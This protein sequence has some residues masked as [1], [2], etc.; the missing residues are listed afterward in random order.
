MRSEASDFSCHLFDNFVAE[1]V[2]V[3]EEEAAV[4]ADEGG[5]EVAGASHADEGLIGVDD[6]APV[7][8]AIGIDLEMVLHEALRR[9]GVGVEEPLYD[10]R[11]DR[12]FLRSDL[13]FFVPSLPLHFWFSRV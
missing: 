13:I 6:G 8:Q 12:H 5:H 3:D 10:E 4:L 9:V 11:M 1:G 7:A 2:G